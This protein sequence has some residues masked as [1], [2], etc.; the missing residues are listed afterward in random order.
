MASTQTPWSAAGS[1]VLTWVL[2]LVVVGYLFFLVAWP[3][4]AGRPAAPS[5]TASRRSATRCSDPDV[6]HALQL[7]VEVAV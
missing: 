7:T 3:T 6:T 2:R 1:P 4:R 5:P